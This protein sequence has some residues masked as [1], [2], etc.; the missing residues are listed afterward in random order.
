MTLLI[1]RV[2]SPHKYSDLHSELLE[3]KKNQN[4][5]LHPWKVSE[6]DE[7]NSQGNK[8]QNSNIRWM[9]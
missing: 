3:R 2:R 8:L 4:L 7:M 9:C 5:C 6:I 1:Y